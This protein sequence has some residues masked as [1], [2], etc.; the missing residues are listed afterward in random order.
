M[1]ALDRINT[2]QEL[3]VQ[4]VDLRLGCNVRELRSE[5]FPRHEMPVGDVNDHIRAC[6]VDR[7]RGDFQ[8]FGEPID[9]RILFRFW[10]GFGTADEQDASNIERIV[11]SNCLSWTKTASDLFA[12]P[13]IRSTFS[14]PTLDV[15]VIRQANDHHEVFQPLMIN[16]RGDLI[17]K[18]S[19][20]N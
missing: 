4:L 1:L 6:S 20:I 13:A 7:D 3:G 17:S 11:R 8:Q 2:H 19:A 16:A 9:Q 5:V 10:N 12:F 18:H 14:A 15:A